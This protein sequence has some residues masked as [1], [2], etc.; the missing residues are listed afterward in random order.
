MCL[1]FARGLLGLGTRPV[2]SRLSSC[3]SLNP[4]TCVCSCSACCTV[5][6]S[7]GKASESKIDR[8]PN[9]PKIVSG[10]T[11]CVSIPFRTAVTCSAMEHVYPYCLRSLFCSGQGVCEPRKEQFTACLIQPRCGL[12]VLTA[13][14]LPGKR[15]PAREEWKRSYQQL[16]SSARATVP[17]SKMI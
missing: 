17:T 4:G 14:A 2:G 11:L 6:L 13:I 8:H 5:L 9:C 7:C 15:R 3:S 10:Y 16:Q 12:M 1:P